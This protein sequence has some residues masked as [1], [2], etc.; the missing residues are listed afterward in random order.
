MGVRGPKPI[1][2]N[3]PKRVLNQYQSGAVNLCELAKIVGLSPATIFRELRRRGVNTSKS[4]R[5]R[6][7]LGKRS[8]RVVGLYSQG[9][10]LRRVAEQTGL[11]REAVRQLLL[12]SRVKLR[13]SWTH[14]PFSGRNGGTGNRKRFAVR[15]RA[16]RLSANLSLSH[17][18][19]RSGHP[20]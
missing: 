10:G 17:L 18:A 1:R 9:L 14:Y 3:L 11:S 12:R 8:E 13:A 20:P 15:F 7:R 16:F 2:V 19:N 4:S 6:L 5:A